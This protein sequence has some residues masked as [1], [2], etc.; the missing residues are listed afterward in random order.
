MQAVLVRE[1]RIKPAVVILY[2][3]DD[4]HAIVNWS[5]DPVG[6]PGQD[7][8]GFP[9]VTGFRIR[10]G[11]PETGKGKQLVVSTV[12]KMRLLATSFFLPF[13]VSIGW[14]QAAALSKCLSKG[15]LGCHGF[16]SCI[17][18]AC[19]HAGIVGPGGDQAPVEGSQ[20]SLAIIVAISQC[21][22]RLGGGDVETRLQ[23]QVRTGG[24]QELV[25]Q[26][27]KGS[28]Q[29]KSATHDKEPLFV[30][31]EGSVAR[32]PLRFPRNR[33]YGWRNR[34]GNNQEP[35]TG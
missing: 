34:M 20:F 24:K 26:L 2:V 25:N 13:I 5:S 30:I 14:Y 10:P 6:G 16:R 31:V 11:F 28:S 22:D 18:Q 21:H 17:D 15:G 1:S 12:K 23:R 9:A 35:A 3:Q 7:G 4:R 27:V 8:C 33:S 19:S 29:G 32:V